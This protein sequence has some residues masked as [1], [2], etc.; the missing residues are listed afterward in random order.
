MGIYM[1]VSPIFQ[2]HTGQWID[3]SHVLSIT[4]PYIDNDFIK[5]RIQFAFMDRPVEYGK[6]IDWPIPQEVLY[7]E[8]RNEA[9][10]KMERD[11]IDEF[12]QGFDRLM[13]FYKL[14]KD[15]L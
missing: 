14:Y 12:N 5:F 8:N 15:S 13:S 1:R 6:E 11:R 2:L 3:L 7:S 9:I 4:P 10:E